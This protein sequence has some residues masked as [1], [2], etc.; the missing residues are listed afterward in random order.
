M[1]DYDIHIKG[2]TIVDG[3]RVPRY[4]GDV[5]LKDGRVAQLGGRAAGSAEQVID[6]DGLIVA[7]RVRRP[8]HPLRRPD[9]LG[10][11]LHHL[12]LAWCDLGRARQ[13]RLRFRSGEARFPVNGRCSPWCAP[14]PSRYESMKQGCMTP[15]GLG[16]HPRVPRQPRSQHR[17]A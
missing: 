2:G 16:D 3:T 12:R 4:R 10:P 6:A 13:L 14:R 7:T 17:S 5:W 1:A 9:P 11:L 15:L 8:P